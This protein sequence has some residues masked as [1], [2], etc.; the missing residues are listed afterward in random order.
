MS[1]VSRKQT[2]RSVSVSGA[3][4]AKLKAY[5]ELNEIPVSRLVETQMG[6]FL[7]TAETT[8]ENATSETKEEI[9]TF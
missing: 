6:E 9:F 2:R 5:C 4:Y 3:T 7:S 1:V 8:S